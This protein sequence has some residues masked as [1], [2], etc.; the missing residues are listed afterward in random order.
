[1]K[2]VMTPQHHHSNRLCFT[3]ALQNIHKQGIILSYRVS[4]LNARSNKIDFLAVL[5]D[6]SKTLKSMNS[7]IHLL[8]V[9]QVELWSH[10]RCCHYHLSLTNR[11]SKL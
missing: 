8:S 4:H 6:T 9:W 1:M 3:N 7:L 2:G 5:T 11:Y 10:S